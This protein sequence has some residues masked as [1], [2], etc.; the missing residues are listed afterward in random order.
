MTAVNKFF[1]ATHCLKS[2]LSHSRYQKRVSNII[3][4]V[5]E[6]NPRLALSGMMDK[7]PVVNSTDSNDNIT[8]ES[9]TSSQEPA[10]HDDEDGETISMQHE[11]EEVT[12]DLE[13]K[14]DD[15]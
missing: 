5:L 4:D 15:M 2:A 11:D 8:N 9:K 13:N 7:Q 12:G 3:D 1:I 10:V 14:D 6:W